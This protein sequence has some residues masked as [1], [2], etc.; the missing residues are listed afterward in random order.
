[1]QKFST[2]SSEFFSFSTDYCRSCSIG[3]CL[4]KLRFFLIKNQNRAEKVKKIKKM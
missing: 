3:D 1:M 4:F 2:Y